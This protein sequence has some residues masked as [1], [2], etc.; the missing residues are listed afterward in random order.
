MIFLTP[1]VFAECKISTA[2]GTSIIQTLQGCADGTA[3]I[4]IDAGAGATQGISQLRSQ[5]STIGSGL[6]R[7]AALFAVAALVISGILYTT[8]NGS[9]ERVRTAKN[10]ALYAILGLVITLISFSLVQAVLMII[11]GFN[12]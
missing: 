12:T 8:S 7:Y 6:M 9:D 10:T 11:Y 1:S 4:N 2:E 5:V 3:G